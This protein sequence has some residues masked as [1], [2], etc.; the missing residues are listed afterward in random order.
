MPIIGAHALLYTSE[1]DA[2][3]AMLRDVFGFPHVD[4]GEGWLIFALPPAELGVHPAEG[5]TY[6]SGTRHQVTFMCDDIEATVRDLRR[7][8]VDVRGE[9]FNEGWGIHVTLV[10][11]GGVEVL[12]YQPLHPIAAHGARA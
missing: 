4:A 7:K 1:P 11:P 12:L 6:E 10:L 2:L 8:G 9:P 3:R 5:P